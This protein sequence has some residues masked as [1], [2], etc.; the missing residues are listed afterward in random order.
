MSDY[1]GVVLLLS[2]TP[3]QREGDGGG[4]RGV[5]DF[6]FSR[7]TFKMDYQNQEKNNSTGMF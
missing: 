1:K 2:Q 6:F 4:E 7:S 3:T 5:G